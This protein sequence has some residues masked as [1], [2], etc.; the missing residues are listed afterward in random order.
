MATA[1]LIPVEEYLT[2]S[3][4]PDREYIDGLAVER[5]LGEYDHGR[6]QTCLGA[7]LFRREREWNIRVVV[8]QRVTVAA[9]RYRVPDVCIISRDRAIEPVITDPPLACI[10]VLSREDRLRSIEQKI[11]DYTA[12]GVPAIWLFDPL[13]RQAFV[14]TLNGLVAPGDGILKVPGTP[15]QIPLKEILADID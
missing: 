3:Y 13:K 8:E 14:C 10:E 15:I 5:N 12:M 7:W 11:E 2:T 4:E 1:T 9:K 6:M